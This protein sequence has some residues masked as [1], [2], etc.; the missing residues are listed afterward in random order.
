MKSSKLATQK[1]G[2]KMED[3]VH[4][5]TT[6][7]TVAERLQ[8]LSR[9]AT[10]D[11]LVTPWRNGK[12][13]VSVQPKT[14]GL[15]LSRKFVE[16][17]YPDDLIN[18]ILRV[19]GPSY[20]CDEIARDEDPGYVRLSLEHDLS[21][22]FPEGDFLRK[23]ILDFGCGAGASTM[24]LFRMFP[25]SDIVGVD[26]DGSLL[27]IA[28]GRARFYSFPQHNLL[29]SPT[30]D[31]LP[32]DLGGEFD[33]VILS[34]VYEH[35]LPN[36]RRSVLAQLWSVLR[37]GGHLVLNQTPHRYS[38]VEAHTTGLPLIN[39]LPD[40]LA[41]RGAC[42]FSRRVEANCSWETLLRRGIRGGSE[43]EVLG[44]LNSFH[45]GVPRLLDPKRTE[46][47]RDRI[48]VWYALSSTQRL[49]AAKKTLHAA[50]KTIKLLTG[51]TIV[52]SLSLVIQKGG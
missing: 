6:G 21:A 12:R 52:P 40:K 31:R 22:Y 32:S 2:G 4:V 41:H 37:T 25:R 8:L 38:P 48:D 30:P 42:L 15:F 23:R 17:T 29:Q 10:A 20:V 18:L 9:N 43:A 50:F 1:A 26:L 35:L 11:L 16:S 24:L 51:K 36:E 7:P 45:D 3:P 34:A 5:P 47:I 28:K 19:K 46:K 33:Y 14:D 27:E 13:T 44:M 49:S 39:Y